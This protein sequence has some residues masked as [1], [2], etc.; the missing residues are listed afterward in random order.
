MTLINGL[1]IDSNWNRPSRYDKSAQH[2]G[3]PRTYVFGGL[4][5]SGAKDKDGAR[6]GSGTI[7][8]LAVADLEFVA[9]CRNLLQIV[10]RCN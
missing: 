10:A 9:L 6:D 4:L 2:C 7:W 8:D 3:I 1:M 5:V